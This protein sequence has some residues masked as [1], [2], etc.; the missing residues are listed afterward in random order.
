MRKGVYSSLLAPNAWLPGGSDGKESA[1]SMQDAGSIPGLG[2]SPGEGNAYP[3]QYSFLKNAV[4]RKAW[5]ATV[6]GVTKT[7]LSN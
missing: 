1:F 3:L 5:R 2:R 7:R 4:D 6:R